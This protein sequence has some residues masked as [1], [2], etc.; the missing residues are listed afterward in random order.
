MRDFATFLGTI[1]AFISAVMATIIFW[2]WVASLVLP[3]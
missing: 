3:S 2:F 1:C